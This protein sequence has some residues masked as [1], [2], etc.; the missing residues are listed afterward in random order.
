MLEI[1]KGDYRGSHKFFGL[2]ALGHRGHKIIL[3]ATGSVIINFQRLTALVLKG[4]KCMG[5][6]IHLHLFSTK[7]GTYF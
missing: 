5:I 2:A 3:L 1:T 6:N 4:Y 7:A